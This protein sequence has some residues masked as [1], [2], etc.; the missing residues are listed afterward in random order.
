MK[1][2]TTLLLL[3]LCLVSVRTSYGQKNNVLDKAG[4]NRM[5]NSGI[6]LYQQGRLNDAISIL[7]TA[8]IKDTANWR[9]LYWMGM[10]FYDLS[11]Y[12][13]AEECAVRANEIIGREE[14]VDVDL[15]KL[16][17]DV[18]HRLGN[19][20]LAAKY[21]KQTAEL[22]GKKIS[23]DMGIPELIDA[24][25]LY[26]K[27]TKAGRK[28]KR[29]ILADAINTVDDEYAPILMNGGRD[30]FFTARKTETTGNN[31]N[32]DDQRYFEDMYH[33][34]WDTVSLSWKMNKLT[35]SEWN[36]NGFDALTYINE[37]GLFGLCTINTSATEKTTKSSDIFEIIGEEPLK[38]S[39]MDVIKNK[40]INT[41]YFEGA[42]SLAQVSDMEQ[43]MIFVSDRKGDVSGTDLYSVSRTDELWQTS[44]RLPNEINSLGDETT[45]YITDDGQ[46]LFFSSRGLPGYGGYDIF[47]SQWIDEKWSAPVNLGLEI[48]SVNDDTHFQINTKTNECVLASMAVRGD[49]FSYD[50]FQADMTGLNFP[51]LKK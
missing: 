39:S 51:F 5:L 32:P 38:W 31:I 33:A 11:S 7:K 49:Y 14:N 1:K 26:L 8:E 3:T 24:C 34:Q 19:V 13:A 47:Y 37:N 35:F 22:M 48:N 15:I 10:S 6:E 28:S 40:S 43:K 45:P 25:E 30:L 42:A 4:I 21:Y 16:L 12:Y 20:D 46:F 2:T 9:V 29:S 44:V 17:G 27:D 41:D 18:N 50:L 36:T 23:T